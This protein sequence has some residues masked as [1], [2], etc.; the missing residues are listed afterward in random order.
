MEP[1]NTNRLNAEYFPDGS[2]ETPNVTC[3]IREARPAPIVT[4]TIGDK[5]FYFTQ[6]YLYINDAYGTTTM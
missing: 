1:T 2:G 5:N 3:I 4:W 6:F